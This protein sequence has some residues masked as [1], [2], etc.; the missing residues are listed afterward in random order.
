MHQLLSAKL[1]WDVSGVSDKPNAL[2]HRRHSIAPSL[3]LASQH[4]AVRNHH[5]WA[6]QDST[7]VGVDAGVTVL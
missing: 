1:G 2:R 5:C 6:F 7:A 3:A 4:A